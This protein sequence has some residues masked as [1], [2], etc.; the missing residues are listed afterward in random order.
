MEQEL[1][2]QICRVKAIVQGRVQGIGFRQ[3]ACDYANSLGLSGYVRNLWDRS[4]E[5]VA[6]GPEHDVHAMIKWL[7]KGPPL[8]RVTHVNVQWQAPSGEYTGFEV[9]Y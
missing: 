7:Q 6:E 8:A 4:I 2:A 3:Y 5:V 1:E 9:S